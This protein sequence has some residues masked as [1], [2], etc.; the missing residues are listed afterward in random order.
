M[1]LGCK[2][3]QGMLATT[4]FYWDLNDETR[5]LT[6]RFAASEVISIR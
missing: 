2:S 5:A 3:A 4:S 1:R 6:K